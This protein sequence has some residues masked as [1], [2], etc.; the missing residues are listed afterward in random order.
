MKIKNA[1]RIW[2]IPLHRLENRPVANNA[3]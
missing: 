3:K 2:P 1:S